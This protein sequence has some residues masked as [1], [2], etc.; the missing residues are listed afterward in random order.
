[1]AAPQ[2]SGFLALV[3]EA[4]KTANKP[5]LGYLNPILYG[6]SADDRVVLVNDIVSGDNGAYQATAGWDAATGF[7]S[8]QAKNLLDKLVSQ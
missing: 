2:W 5:A 7:G 6:F 1:M 8:M 3:A 4:R